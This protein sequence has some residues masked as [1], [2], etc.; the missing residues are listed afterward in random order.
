MR[1]STVAV[2][3]RATCGMEVEW[4]RNVTVVVRTCRAS[5][6]SGRMRVGLDDVIVILLRSALAEVT[7][8]KDDGGRLVRKWSVETVHEGAQ[9]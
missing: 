9:G 7:A 2:T 4:V 6:A 5:W 1:R 8:S 3:G